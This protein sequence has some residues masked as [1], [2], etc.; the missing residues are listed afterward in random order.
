MIAGMRRDAPKSQ[1]AS[2]RERITALSYAP[3][4]IKLVW[5]TSRGYTVVMI[6]LRLLLAFSPVATLWIGKLIIDAVVAATLNPG[7]SLAPL[8]RLVALEAAI[9][10][11]GEALARASRLVESLLGDLFSNHTS[12]RLME[13]AATLDLYQFEDPDFYDRLERARRQ[14]TGRLILLTQ[15]LSMGQDALTLLSLGAALFVF[16]PWLLLL[17]AVAVLPSFL[18]ETHFA[19]LQYSLLFRW[20]PDRRQDAPS[21]CT[22]S[23]S[24]CR[25]RGIASRD[26]RYRKREKRNCGAVN[27]ISIYIFRHDVTAACDQRRLALAFLDLRRQLHLYFAPLAVAGRVGRQIC[28]R[29][30]RCDIAHHTDKRSFHLLRLGA[31]QFTARLLDKHLQAARPQPDVAQDAGRFTANALFDAPSNGFD[32]SA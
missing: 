6:A 30:T 11:A 13:H 21:N 20:M 2:W 23:F 29:V 9:V 26:P 28:Q 10:L 15:L 5:Q 16:S 7:G 32:Q 31:D 19:A 17:L 25:R 8:W 22:P 18:G 27:V 24:P 14:T 4:L 12:V 1:P 3:P